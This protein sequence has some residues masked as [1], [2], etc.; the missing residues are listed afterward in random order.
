MTTETT[1]TNV[2]AVL[3]TRVS[4][5]E[6][7]LRGFGLDAQMTE[8]RAHAA[9]QQ[10]TIVGE[11]TDDGYSGAVLGR[12][13]LDCLRES[14]RMGAVDVVLM[15]DPDR[16]SRRLAHALLLLEELEQRARVEFITTQRAQTPEGTLLLHMKAAIGEFERLKIV[17]RTQY[18]KREKARRGLVVAS[19]PYGYRFAPPIQDGAKIKNSGRLEIYE[20]E[21]NTI[22]MI[23]SWLIDEG[24]SLR[25]IVDEL[26][27]L[28]IPSSGPGRRWG[29]TTVRRI[30]ASPRYTGR[31]FFNQSHTTAQG[32]RLRDR[33]DW[34]PVDIPAIVTPER[35]A[36]ALAA[37]ARNGAPRRTARVRPLRT[38]WPPAMLAVRPPLRVLPQS[39]API[40]PLLCAQ[41]PGGRGA[42]PRTVDLCDRRRGGCLARDLRS[43]SPAR[44][45]PRGHGAL[46]DQPG[47]SRC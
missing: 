18:G 1:T 34:I 28:G 9:T 7:A 33:A 40:L 37:L 47:R 20:P 38:A 4:S 5:D 26:R 23:Y 32:R 2:R 24:R 46:R 39:R 10:Y 30:V 21:A 12:P 15:Y 11:F 22:R 43:A 27:R 36:A 35:H 42:V 31:V 19:H 45:A 16:L 13:G 8:L 25:S 3:Y 6:Q 41:P 44:G 17:Q 29:T 14:V